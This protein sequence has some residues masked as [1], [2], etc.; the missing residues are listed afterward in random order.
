M[1]KRKTFILLILFSAAA[2]ALLSF[3]PALA[4]DGFGGGPPPG[5][6]LGLEYG[7][8]TG[9][10]REDVR[11]TIAR[12]ISAAL[13]LLGII[14]VVIIIYAGF[15]WMTSGGNEE[16]VKSAQKTLMAAVIGLVIILS[17]YAIT[18]FVM[19]QLFK[20]TTGYEYEQ[21]MFD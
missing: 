2:L 20:A 3:V 18:R 17:A 14:A 8:A 10:G 15:K 6:Y 9:L 19:T 21:V 5:P 7:Q 13:G 16:T 4:F 11:F 1:L 12:I